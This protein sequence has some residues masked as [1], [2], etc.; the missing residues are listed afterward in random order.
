MMNRLLALLETG[1]PTC[2]RKVALLALF[3]SAAL[4]FGRPAPPIAA[5]PADECLLRFARFTQS[6]AEK[7]LRNGDDLEAVQE[8]LYRN[9]YG[10][11]RLCRRVSRAKTMQEV[12][13][14]SRILY[15]VLDIELQGDGL[16]NVTFSRCFFSRFYSYPVCQVMSAMDGG[17]FAGLSGGRQLVF[18]ARITEGQT[19]CRAHLAAQEDTK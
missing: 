18:S 2:M 15:R 13:D 7:L 19:C 8:R 3:R 16:G 5:L 14:L 12:M 17:L 1:M 4:A 6:Q 10:L 11:G 9:A